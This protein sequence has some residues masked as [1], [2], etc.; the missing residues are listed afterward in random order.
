MILNSELKQ[1]GAFGY[2]KIK[3]KDVLKTTVPAKHMNNIVE[4][5]TVKVTASG[6]EMAWDQTGIF[7]P[8]KF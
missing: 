4:Q 5:F 2:D 7:I 8:I 6:V 1:W 3:D